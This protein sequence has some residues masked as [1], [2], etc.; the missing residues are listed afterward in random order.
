M[1]EDQIDHVLALIDRATA[2]GIRLTA[3]RGRL[4]GHPTGPVD[5]DLAHALSVNCD[6]LRIALCAATTAR[7]AI[8]RARSCLGVR[9]EPAKAAT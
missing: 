9:T 4:L 6:S 5:P 2:A 8:S 7:A 3:E 1:R